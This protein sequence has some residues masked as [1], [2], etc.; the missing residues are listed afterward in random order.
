M[1]KF[2]GIFRMP[3]SS[4]MIQLYI[5]LMVFKVKKKNSPHN[6]V[7][8][9]TSWKKN[10][11]LQSNTKR[12]QMAQVKVDGIVFPKKCAIAQSELIFAAL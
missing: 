9:E 12:I 2:H 1:A 6:K 10:C 5:S 7:N 3:F 4:K 8:S 11:K